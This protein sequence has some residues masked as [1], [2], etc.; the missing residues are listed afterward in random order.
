MYANKYREIFKKFKNPKDFQ[1]W[2]DVNKPFIFQT[3]PVGPIGLKYKFKPPGF[4]YFII[5][6]DQI[7]DAKI[8][9]LHFK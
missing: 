3:Q 6:N 4:R 2:F 1:I 9:S 5:K 7:T 8:F